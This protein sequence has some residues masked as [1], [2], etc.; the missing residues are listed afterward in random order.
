MG[1][2]RRSATHSL[3]PGRRPRHQSWIAEL[4]NDGEACRH[5]RSNLGAARP[6]RFSFASTG[7]SGTPSASSRMV[8]SGAKRVCLFGPLELDRL[9]QRG[10]DRWRAPCGRGN[11]VGHGSSGASFT[12]R[13]RSGRQAFRRGADCLRLGNCRRS[14][15]HS[16]NPRLIR[17][18]ALRDSRAVSRAKQTKQ[19]TAAARRSTRRGQIS[20]G[21]AA[22]A[23]SFIEFG[24]IA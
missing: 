5:L 13:R 9:P 23:V 17:S 4:A 6:A 20:S 11:Q 18:T 15:T 8:S 10:G 2:C 3:N 22:E 1:N 12:W 24:R 19:R 14:A 21:V 16:L 7:V